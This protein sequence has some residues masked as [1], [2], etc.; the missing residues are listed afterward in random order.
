MS[1][2]WSTDHLRLIADMRRTMAVP[3]IAVKLQERG[4]QI[5]VEF[6]NHLIRRAR[7]GKFGP[8]VA[9]W[10]PKKELGVWTRERIIAVATALNKAGRLTEDVAVSVGATPGQIK[11]MI[12]DVRK[13][14]DAELIALFPRKKS[15]VAEKKK[16]PPSWSIKKTG[17]RSP[18]AS[19]R[20]SIIRGVPPPRTREA[21]PFDRNKC[22]WP[23]FGAVDEYGRPIP[24]RYVQDP[25]P[26]MRPLM[27]DE[28]LAKEDGAVYC[29]FHTWLAFQGREWQD[30]A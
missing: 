12:E 11:H 21:D 1:Q 29:D 13:G 3:E 20:L 14:H 27:C 10:F 26:G 28:P 24:G 5:T 9:E 7:N 15:Q 25:R 8:E 22:C 6:L 2:T 19:F 18:P 17:D 23:M 16:P 4:F 30:A